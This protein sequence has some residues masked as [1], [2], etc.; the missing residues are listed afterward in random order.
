MY[1]NKFIHKVYDY[2]VYSLVA[3]KKSTSTY[4]NEM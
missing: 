2:I 1:K 3:T 4:K